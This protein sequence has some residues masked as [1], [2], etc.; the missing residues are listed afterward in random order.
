MLVE[1]VPAS[2][3]V[4]GTFG[5]AIVAGAGVGNGLPACW[6]LHL[7]LPSTLSI[8]QACPAARAGAL[9]RGNAD[10]ATRDRPAAIHNYHR[11]FG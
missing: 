5:S 9:S 3:D 7:I 1:R 4:R 6:A 10:H 2:G 8:L 11:P